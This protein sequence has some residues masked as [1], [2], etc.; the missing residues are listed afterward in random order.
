M[1]E[2]TGMLTCSP[3]TSSE[4][5][6]GGEGSPKAMDLTS[7]LRCH[8][9]E[10]WSPGRATHYSPPKRPS[11]ANS[12]YATF[13][14]TASQQQHADA[15]LEAKAASTVLLSLLSST[16]ATADICRLHRTAVD[17]VCRLFRILAKSHSQ[18]EQEASVLKLLIG[19]TISLR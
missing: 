1:K 13:D 17:P 10:I 12:K 6:E 2:I 9:E 8:P 18:S 7:K 14:R 15:L 4:R 3:L 11:S 19:E 16:A 5:D